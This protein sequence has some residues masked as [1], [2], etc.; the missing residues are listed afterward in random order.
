MTKAARLNIR[1]TEVLKEKVERVAR[2]RQ[3]TV[4]E[5]ITDYIKCLPLPQD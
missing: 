5:L 4:S 1:I 3:I 2:E